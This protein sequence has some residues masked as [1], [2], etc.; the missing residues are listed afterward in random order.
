MQSTTFTPSGDFQRDSHNLKE[1]IQSIIT[2][3][4][5]AWPGMAVQMA[6][7]EAKGLDVQVR[8]STNFAYNAK[9]GVTTPLTQRAPKG[10]S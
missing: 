2:A 6:F 7:S 9:A 8:P 4:K 5:A 10:K 3:Y 1:T